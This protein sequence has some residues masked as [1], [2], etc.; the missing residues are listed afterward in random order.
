MTQQEF[1]T[2]QPTKGLLGFFHLQIVSPA[3]S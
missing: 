2:S 1:S 3:F